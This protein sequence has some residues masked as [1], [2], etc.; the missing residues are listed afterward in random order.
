MSVPKAVSTAPSRRMLQL[1]YVEDNHHDAKLALRELERAGY[2]LVADVVR[3][4]EDF[5]AA[6]RSK[7]HDIVLADYRLPH[8]SGMEALEVLKKVRPQIPLIIVTGAVGDEAAVECIK[9]GAADCVLKDHLDRLPLAVERALREKDVREEHRRAEEN[10]GLL[11][12]IVESC[13]DAIF[14]K[15]LDGTVLSWNRGAEKMYG[16]TAQ[17]VVGQPVSTLIPADRKS[18]FQQIMEKIYRGE[19]VRQLET[20]RLAKGGRRVDA[21]ITVSPIRDSAGRVTGASVIV[22]DIGGAARPENGKK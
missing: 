2:R 8:W 15:A 6:L 5:L 12:A 14:S 22:R 19:H 13:E 21:S 4:R 17:E 16:Y 10:F 1:L 9:R 20:V 7:D 18:E 11:A 3:E